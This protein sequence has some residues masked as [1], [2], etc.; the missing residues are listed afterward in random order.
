[1]TSGLLEGPRQQL[2][3]HTYTDQDVMD[4]DDR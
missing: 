1:M 2:F 3:G 4:Y